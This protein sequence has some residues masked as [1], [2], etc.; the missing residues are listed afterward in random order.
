[1]K[2]IYLDY[3]SLTPIDKG[4]MKEINKYSSR[5]YS[6]PSALYTSAVKSKNA[7]IDAKERIAKVIHAH[8]DEI[9]FTSGGT[10][11]NALTLAGQ[12]VIISA[13]EHSSIIKT[14]NDVTV[15][16]V[17]KNGIVDLE[18][19]KKSITEETTLVSVMLVN[20]E[21]GTI[22]PIH[23]IAKIVRDARKKF[24]KGDDKIPR[25]FPLLHTDASQAGLILLYVEK[26]GVDLMTLDG[27]KIYGPRGIGML[28]V[29][30]DTLNIIRAGTE[31][32]PGI[33][34]FAYALEL[35]EKKRENESKRIAELKNYFITELF[36]I[37]KDIK[38]NGDIEYPR[39][40]KNISP[41]ILNISIPNIDNEFFILKLDVKGI[42][43][44]TKSACL[45]D[46]D[47]SYV[48]Q[49][50]GGNSK[51]SVRFSFGKYTTKNDLKY[52][53]KIIKKILQK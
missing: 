12:K 45:K 44:S 6:N 3:A 50:I 52:S 5:D 8:P 18:L 48:L 36:K 14:E 26:L 4:V 32:V 23:E 37:N 9:V 49:A 42:E 41:H 38:V 31:N 21:I 19:L 29:K 15:I 27:S 20:N 34:G 22:E 11:S 43:C 7:V 51:N 2:R 13:I 24:E 17:D 39:N 1:M 47:E 33:M 16:T 28:Y 53:I 46:H 10:E 40:N 35:V 30:R 25:K